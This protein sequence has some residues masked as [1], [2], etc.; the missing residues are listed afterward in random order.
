MGTKDDIEKPDGGFVFPFP[1]A[2]HAFKR[3]TC[4]GEDFFVSINTPFAVQPSAL[5]ALIEAVS[6]ADEAISPT[7]RRCHHPRQPLVIVRER[8]ILTR[9]VV[10]RVL[11]VG[12][13]EAEGG[14]ERAVVGVHGRGSFLRCA[15]IC[16]LF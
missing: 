14:E 3:R 8:E 2:D 5:A 16:R 11:L 10:A 7:G 12:V 6:D 9:E 4:D 1:L 15:A 13:G